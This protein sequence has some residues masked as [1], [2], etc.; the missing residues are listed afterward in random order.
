MVV[1]RRVRGSQI[2]IATVILSHES[3]KTWYKSLFLIKPQFTDLWSGHNITYPKNC[4]IG[5]LCKHMIGHLI[6]NISVLQCHHCC[7]P[8]LQQ[9]C[10]LWSLWEPS[11]QCSDSEARLLSL[12][13]STAKHWQWDLVQG[14]YLSASPF[15][16]RWNRVAYLIDS[17]KN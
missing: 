1:K 2:Q 9:I 7:C 12:N 5:Y 3:C 6:N 13:P 8:H 15:P 4:G 11:M 16:H 17:L 10:W 14:P